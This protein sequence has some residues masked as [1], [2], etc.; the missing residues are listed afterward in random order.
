MIDIEPIRTFVQREFVY[1]H[2]HLGDGD[3]LF[4]DVVDSLGI[5]DLVDVVE[6]TYGIKIGPEELLVTNFSSL[7]ALASLIERKR[8]EHPEPA[9]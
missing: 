6:E 2:G 3:V 4:P 1:D 7:A 5:M 9:Q 8:D